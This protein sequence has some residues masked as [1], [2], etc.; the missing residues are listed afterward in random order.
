MSEATID[1]TVVDEGAVADT[2][3]GGAAAG[4][5]DAVFEGACAT[6]KSRSNFMFCS[7]KSRHIS[8]RKSSVEKDSW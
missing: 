6:L 8:T 2:A 4:V 1:A 7:M 3:A 5:T